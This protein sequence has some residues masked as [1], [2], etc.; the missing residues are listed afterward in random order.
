MAPG[1]VAGHSLGEYSALVCAGSL[2]LS[3]AIRLVNR[4]GRYM[5]EAVP[6]GRGA[7]AALLGLSR[8]AVEAL[9][10]DEAGC[11]VLSAANFNSPEQTV[12]AGTSEAVARAV[13]AAPGRGAK[14]AIPLPVSAPFHC[15]LMVPA[16]DRLTPDLQE[17]SFSDPACPLISNVDARPLERGSEARA[18]LIRQVTAPV[19]WEA[20][21]REMFRLGARIFVEVGPGKILC[22]LVRRIL[23]EARTFNVEDPA[24]LEKTLSALQG[25]TR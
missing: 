8:D 17:T 15:E 23:P 18:G 14:R 3:D 1:W 13:A 24:S 5:Q 16:R 7:M 25:A 11:D 12:I 22:G 10:R 4:R 21:V 20:S 6:V 9:C 19:R 2:R